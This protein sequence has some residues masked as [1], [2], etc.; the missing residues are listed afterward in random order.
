MQHICLKRNFFVLLLIALIGNI[1]ICL[2]QESTERAA[3]PSPLDVKNI[4]GL[5]AGYGGGLGGPGI[6]YNVMSVYSG[7]IAPGIMLTYEHTFTKRFGLGASA[8]FSSATVS[9]SNVPYTID[10]SQQLTSGT[11]NDKIHGT[12][13]GL[14]A[15]GIYHFKGSKK[16][17]PYAGFIGGVTFTKLSSTVTTAQGTYP[18]HEFFPGILTGV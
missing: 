1:S 16:F 13:I 6:G 11:F 14:A 2:G 17:D 7:T 8:S 9:A 3:S 12:Y 10:T 18:S 15:R 4:F 5:G